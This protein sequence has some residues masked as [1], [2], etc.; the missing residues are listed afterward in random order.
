MDC[1]C[2]TNINQVSGNSWN[3]LIQDNSPF[4]RHEFLA[5]LEQTGC[6]KADNGWLAHHI[7]CFDDNEL[8]AAMPFYVKGHSYGEYIFDWAWADAYHRHGFE[9][10]PKGLCAIPYT[11][12]SATKILLKNGVNSDW[13]RQQIIKHALAKANEL[14]LSSVHALFLDTEELRAWTNQGFTSRSS[15]Q[16]HWQ[17]NNYQN[18]DDYL[19]SFTSV[20]RKKI[21][22]QRKSLDS[23]VIEFKTLKGS[24]ITKQNWRDF[25]RFY[26]STIRLHG[27]MTYLNPDF[28]QQVGESMPDQTL[29]IAAYVNKKNI[30]SALFFESTTTLFGRYWGCDIEI[31]NLHFETCYYQAIDY[32]IK[33]K[34]QYFEAGTQ[35][36]HK[37]SRG[38]LPVKILSAHWLRHP[39][40]YQAIKDHIEIETDHVDQY[41][42]SLQQHSPFKEK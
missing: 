19:N 42:Q 31:N 22:Q 5:A 4:T 38:L 15:Y 18:F 26:K 39:Q 25:Y 23:S 40:F 34:I 10:Y 13:A 11:P 1:H 21:R 17:N 36:E 30:A 14:Q 33:N 8:V 3:A 28:F 9:Y 37:L 29:L 20:K 2:I 24:E 41:L 7:V 6:T 16:F 32:C 35:G 12:A 27:A